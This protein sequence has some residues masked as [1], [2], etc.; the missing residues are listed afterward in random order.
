[1]SE[2]TSRV[3][4]VLLQLFNAPLQQQVEYVEFDPHSCF[5]ISG[6]RERLR[7]EMRQMLKR[8]IAVE[9]LD[10]EYLN[11]DDRIERRIVPVHARVGA[12]LGDGGWRKF[13]GPILLETSQDIR[14]TDHR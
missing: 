2:P 4:R 12:R 1:M 8:C 6:R 11:R 14:D 5:A 10:K 3:E 7:R 13:F 9:Y